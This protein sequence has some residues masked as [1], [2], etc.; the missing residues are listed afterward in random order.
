MKNL[1]LAGGVALNCVGNG[2]I[3]REGAVREHLDSAG[4][5]RRRRRAG[6]GPV[7]L[8][9][10]ARTTRA[11]RE[12]ARPAARLAAGAALLRRADPRGSSTPPAPS[13]TPRRATRRPCRQRRRADRRRARSSAGSRDGWSSGRGPWAAGASSG[14]ARSQR[15]AV[16]DEPEDQVPRVLPPVRARACCGR[17][18]P[19]TS[20]CRPQRGQPLHAAGGA[21]SRARSGSTRRPMPAL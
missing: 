12:P 17:T 18:W 15:D 13:T 9:S 4:G 21:R 14:D 20:R 7:R 16:G 8:A 2:R 6:R 5:R 11:R 1:C 19:S 10:T 3:L